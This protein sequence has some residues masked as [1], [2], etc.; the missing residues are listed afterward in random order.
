MALLIE[1]TL[2]AVLII[3]GQTQAFVAGMQE[4]VE[5]INEFADTW[6]PRLEDSVLV[7]DAADPGSIE[8]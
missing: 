7:G 6:A 2:K 4:M 5:N 1:R 3:G 8:V